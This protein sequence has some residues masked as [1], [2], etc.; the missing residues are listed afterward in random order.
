MS[1]KLYLSASLMVLSHTGGYEVGLFSSSL[2]CKFH[3]MGYPKAAEHSRVLAWRGG[4]ERLPGLV[5]LLASRKWNTCP[6]NPPELT[7]TSHELSFWQQLLSFP[8]VLPSS[9]PHPSFLP[10]RYSQAACEGGS[11]TPLATGLKLGHNYNPPLIL[12]HPFPATAEDEFLPCLS[13]APCPLSKQ[14]TPLRTLSYQKAWPHCFTSVTAMSYHSSSWSVLI[15]SSSLL[16][17]SPPVLIFP[18]PPLF[19]NLF[20]EIWI[21]IEVIY[22]HAG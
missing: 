9:T 1:A 20:T 18:S 2:V 10:S 14:T 21:S 6:S 3:E 4:G 13:T 19:S 8:P 16:L 12:H 7:Q 15:L 11:Y 22:L 17:S 5:A